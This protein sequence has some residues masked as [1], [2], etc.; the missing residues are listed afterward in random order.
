MLESLA[1]RFVSSLRLTLLSTFIRCPAGLGGHSQP[2]QLFAHNCN[3]YFPPMRGSPVFK[4]E[5][6]LPRSKLHFSIDNRHRLAG[7]RQDHADV[8]WHIVAA[9]GTMPEVIGDLKH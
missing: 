5:N 6:A 8:R 2:L 3:K 1:F 7:P 9:L 4:E